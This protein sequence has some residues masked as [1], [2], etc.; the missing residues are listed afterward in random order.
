MSIW[1]LSAEA[2]KYAQ[3]RPSHPKD[4]V[5]IA[6]KFLREE[7]KG[8][9]HQAVDVGCGTGLSTQNLYGEF[10]HNLGVDASQAM[11]DQANQQGLPG[12]LVFAAS[13]AEN[14][15]VGSESTQLVIAGRAIHYFDIAA[16]YAEVDR[17]LVRNGVL[18]YYSVDF[19]AVSSPN[20]KKFGERI[21][22]LFWKQLKSPRLSGYW[23]VNPSNKQIV[24]WD[25]RNFYLNVLTAPYPSTRTD[26][27]VAGQRE[28]SVEQ[29]AAELSTYSAIVTLRERDGDKAAD[30]ML[31]D[32]IAVGRQIASE[33]KQDST[34]LVATDNF[35]MVMSRKP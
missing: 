19:P 16:F 21:H 6:K 27:T 11:I 18:C 5:T 30:E 7:Y 15:P 2:A 13:R 29:L 34:N 10:E 17:V 25:R 4:I 1:K 31:D 20:N 23:P 26:E 14:L 33:E 35:F 9:A 3:A 32:F 12:S 24:D 8:P 28:T 22:D